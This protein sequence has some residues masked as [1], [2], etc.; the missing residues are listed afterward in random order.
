MDDAATQRKFSQR[1]VQTLKLQLRH[2]SRFT[3]ELLHQQRT[4][5]TTCAGIRFFFDI[6]D[7]NSWPQSACDSFVS[8]WNLSALEWSFALKKDALREFV[9]SAENWESLQCDD[10]DDDSRITPLD[11]RRLLLL[12]APANYTRWNA[13]KKHLSTLVSSSGDD[14]SRLAA[15][16][17]ELHFTSLVLGRAYKLGEV[18]THRLWLWNRII[19]MI[20][21]RET[22]QD[23]DDATNFK[24]QA[25]VDLHEK[26]I[27]YDAC[28]NHPMNLNAWQYRRQMV[29]LRSGN[30]L[31]PLAASMSHDSTTSSHHFAL[32]TNG[33]IALLQSHSESAIAF[34]R[35]HHRDA[36]CSRFLVDLITS[37]GNIE[38]RT[39]LDDDDA[40]FSS[41]I[42][43]L[44]IS[45]M[46]LSSRLLAQTCNSGHECLWHLRLG[47]IVFA[48][49]SQM[50]S[51]TS[52]G[53]NWTVCD[54][55]EFV[56]THTTSV[57]GC[58]SVVSDRLELTSCSGSLLFHQWHAARYG[59]MLI[60]LIKG[61]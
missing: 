6:L 43:T 8:D 38:N 34:L 57:E 24:L 30:L 12:C 5:G 48:M 33:L 56:E 11:A 39:E 46:T 20:L 59:I 36:S 10:D 25:W 60:R 42:C 14:D 9:A 17:E 41:A 37:A 52:L 1:A 51:K 27:L 49:R 47:L 29:A 18:W 55:L 44:W 3:L 40:T 2:L 58:F 4:G 7:G 15:L 13:S 32:S 16:L 28:H 35:T 31:F 54:E 21:P 23:D 19:P 61:V 45:L 53:G 22:S 26:N 50:A